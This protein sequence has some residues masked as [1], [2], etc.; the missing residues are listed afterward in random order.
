MSISR[1]SRRPNWK[2]ATST[3]GFIFKQRS[4]ADDDV[5]VDVDAS[6][7]TMRRP[8]EKKVEE[9]EQE[10]RKKYTSREIPDWKKKMFAFAKWISETRDILAQVKY[11]VVFKR[12][13]LFEKK[14]LAN[15]IRI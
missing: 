1:A 10:N 6:E 11:A 8:S 5:D 9:K 14:C 12:E 15:R 2:P 3:L 4:A 7:K 13:I